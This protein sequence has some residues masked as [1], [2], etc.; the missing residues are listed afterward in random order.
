MEIAVASMND[1]VPGSM[2]NVQAGGQSV[3]IA[4]VNGEYFAIGNI[5][6]HMGCKISA[7]I[8]EAEKAQCPCHGSVFNVRTGEVI[9]GPA[10][11]PEPSYK[12]KVS[13]T[14]ILLTV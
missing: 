11:K 3:L 14:Q 12:L 6:T 1:I 8:L 9:K 10:K 2:K 13:G 5:C 4:N 7:G